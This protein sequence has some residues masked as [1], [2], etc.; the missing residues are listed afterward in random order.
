VITLTGH[1]LANGDVIL[2]STTGTLPGGLATAT[3]YVV[4]D[5]TTDTFKL[6]PVTTAQNLKNVIWDTD[7][8]IVRRQIDL[9]SG[10]AKHQLGATIT[11]SSGGITANAVLYNR[12]LNADAGAPKAAN[13]GLRWRLID[14]DT[15][16]S[17]PDA[18]G[19]VHWQLLK[20][21]S[22]ILG[23]SIS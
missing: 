13:F 20:P 2:L 7:Q 23:I 16:N 18:R 3:L 12:I 15:E 6:A 19:W 17:I 8:P 9:M 22:G 11:R 14:F 21:E 5:A 1:G 10:F 4:R